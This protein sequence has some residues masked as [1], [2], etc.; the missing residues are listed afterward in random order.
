MDGGVVYGALQEQ[1]RVNLLFMGLCKNSNESTCCLW[2]FART[3]TS[4]LDNSMTE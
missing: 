1:Q 4:Q 2:G 3:A